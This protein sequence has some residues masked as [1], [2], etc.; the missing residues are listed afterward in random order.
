MAWHGMAWHGMAW[1]GMACNLSS[2][3]SRGTSFDF[4]TLRGA[5]NTKGEA[6]YF[7][8]ELRG[9]LKSEEVFLTSV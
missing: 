8:N 5:E 9:V 4:Q 1:H 2:N 6:E 7:F 3:T